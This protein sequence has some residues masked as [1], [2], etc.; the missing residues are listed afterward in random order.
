MDSFFSPHVDPSTPNAD[1]AHWETYQRMVPHVW[2]CAN[3][4][5]EA[6][7]EP[8]RAAQLLTKAGS[9]LQNRGRFTEVERYYELA[10]ELHADLRGLP[11]M[12]AAA[13]ASSLINLTS[14][15]GRK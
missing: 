14:T 7:I 1:L 6:S 5:R 9:Y 4:A 8:L 10:Y 2:I 12:V 3:W 11:P 13:K 15:L